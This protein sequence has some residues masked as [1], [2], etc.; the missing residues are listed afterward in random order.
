MRR[1]EVL[2]SISIISSPDPMT[3]CGLL[4]ARSF[5]T[6]ESGWEGGRE[7]GSKASFRLPAERGS[8]WPR[9]GV[10]VSA[11]ELRALAGLSGDGATASTGRLVK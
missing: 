10:S 11:S 9:S 5:K 1:V 7:G 2:V 6:G 8:S 3:A 4:H